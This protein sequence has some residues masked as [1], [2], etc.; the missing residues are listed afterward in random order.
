MYNKIRALFDDDSVGYSSKLSST[1]ARVWGS[2]LDEVV[3]W[4]ITK[5]MGDSFRL[6]SQALVGY[7]DD[8]ETSDVS[9]PSHDLSRDG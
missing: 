3:V 7:E 2:M 1:V 6:H 8:M 4:G 9:T 5:L